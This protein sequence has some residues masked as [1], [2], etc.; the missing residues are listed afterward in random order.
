MKTLDLENTISKTEKANIITILTKAALDDIFLEE[1]LVNRKEILE[2]YNISLEAREALESGDIEWVEHHVVK[3][4]ELQ[5]KLLEC[6][7]EQEVW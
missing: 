5:K 2:K 1:F 4:D 6:E 7:L 3:L